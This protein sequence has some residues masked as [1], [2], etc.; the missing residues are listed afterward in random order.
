LG[1]ILL[2]EQWCVQTARYQIWGDT[3]PFWG[4]GTAEPGWYWR[5]WDWAATAGREICE[6]W[7]NCS[8]TGASGAYEAS[9][10][11]DAAGELAGLSPY[12]VVD[13]LYAIP[14]VERYVD[15]QVSKDGVTWPSAP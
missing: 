14:N 4:P 9:G 3:I 10:I 15:V 5:I 12:P 1:Q 7:W 8:Y 11:V 2:F 6:L 13:N